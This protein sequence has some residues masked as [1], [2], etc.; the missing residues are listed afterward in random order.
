MLKDKVKDDTFSIM[1]G[2]AIVS[3][4]I[5]HCRPFPQLETFVNA[6]HLAVFFF[7]AG[8]FIKSKHLESTKYFI[9]G[10][11]KRIMMPFFSAN[12]ICLILFDWLVHYNIEYTEG[13]TG[14]FY[15]R[16]LA[17]FSKCQFTAHIM[18][19]TWFLPAL[20]VSLLLTFSVLK[21][22]P[23]WSVRMLIIFL[24]IGFSKV[25][26]YNNWLNVWGMWQCCLI[27]PICLAGN[28]FTVVREVYDN[29]TG[30][31]KTVIQIVIYLLI[32]LL[33]L[34]QK[35]S[36][37]LQ[38]GRLGYMNLMGVYG[39]AM[40]GSL[41]IYDVAR[42]MNSSR[43]LKLK[44]TLIICGDHSFA[45][46]ILHFI[47]FKTVTYLYCLIYGLPLRNVTAHPII[48]YDSYIWFIPYLLSGIVLPILCDK[49]YEKLKTKIKV[50]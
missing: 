38:L 24:L 5:G 10:K 47:A 11:F 3:V 31:G 17:L 9:V 19:A 6:Y 32:L 44:K 14:S 29:Y 13:V 48:K 16:L 4:V 30:G 28:Y 42:L 49:G 46:M 12:L 35:L 37:G 15:D 18:G 45:I 21:V 7:I 50:A 2:L 20:F 25:A 22:S 23:K 26:I 39:C 36:G 41:M 33:L 27:V 40:F 1:K 8:F 43:F 34:S